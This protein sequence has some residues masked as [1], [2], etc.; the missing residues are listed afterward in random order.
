MKFEREFLVPKGYQED[1]K[2]QENIE[3]K[4]T[5]DMKKRL[6]LEFFEHVEYDNVYAVE[7]HHT[8][9]DRIEGTLHQLDLEM[10]DIP[11]FEMCKLDFTEDTVLKPKTSFISKLRNCFK[12]LRS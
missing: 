2:M 5:G 12:Y 10:K 6:L 7:L 11:V 3:K 9:E 1:K 4:I 8:T